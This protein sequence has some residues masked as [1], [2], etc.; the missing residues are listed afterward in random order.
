MAKKNKILKFV[1]ENEPTAADHGVPD[2]N[3]KTEGQSGAMFNH[4]I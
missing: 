1:V 3:L 2:G 4:G